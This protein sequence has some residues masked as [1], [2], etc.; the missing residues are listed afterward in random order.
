MKVKIRHIEQSESVLVGEVT[1]GIELEELINFIK[2]SGG[3]WY[4]GDYHTDIFHQFVLDDN[5][6]YDEIFCSVENEDV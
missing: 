4:E 6:F 1:T 2:R 5:E 3:V